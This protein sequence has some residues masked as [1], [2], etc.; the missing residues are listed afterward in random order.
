MTANNNK[1]ECAIF[2]LNLEKR[3]ELIPISHEA[4]VFVLSSFT[5]F[6]TGSA[7]LTEDLL[8]EFIVIFEEILKYL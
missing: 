1:A 3:I 4:I 5:K 8:E 7:E 2:L 6:V